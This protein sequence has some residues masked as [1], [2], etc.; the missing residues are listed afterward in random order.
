[1]EAKW[2]TWRERSANFQ[3]IG[4]NCEGKGLMG[5]GRLGSLNYKN[6][7][8]LAP[9]ITWCKL[10]LTPALSLFFMFTYN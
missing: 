7:S 9:Y 8:F 6:Y 1:M 4:V 5:R 10:S 3:D 2:L